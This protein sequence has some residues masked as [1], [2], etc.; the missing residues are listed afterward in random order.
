MNI[1]YALKYCH[2]TNTIKVVSELTRRACKKRGISGRKLLTF[3]L[4]AIASLFPGVSFS[5]ASRGDIPSVF[6]RW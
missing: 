6:Y 4:I 2:I 5:S 1:I 3:P